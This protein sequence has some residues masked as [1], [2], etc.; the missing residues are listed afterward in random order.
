MNQQRGRG[1][2]AGRGGNLLG[3]AGAYIS[4]REDAGRAGL[5]NARLTRLEAGRSRAAMHQV[6][7][8][9]DEFLPRF[10]LQGSQKRLELLPAIPAALQVILHQRQRF[11]CVLAGQ[12]HL[13]SQHDALADTLP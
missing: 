6:V 4:R 3:A 5:Q 11:G 9:D 12:V 10:S 13:R 7:P 2:F 8:G 1:P